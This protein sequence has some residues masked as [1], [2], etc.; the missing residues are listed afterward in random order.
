MAP[1][2]ALFTG[3]AA[4]RQP[5]PG[6][7]GLFRRDG[8]EKAIRKPDQYLTDGLYIYHLWKRLLTVQT[9][10]NECIYQCL[11][12]TDL[13]RPRIGLALYSRKCIEKC[14]FVG[15]TLPVNRQGSEIF[16]R[17]FMPNQTIRRDEWVH[18][19]GCLHLLH[20]Q[21]S[22]MSELFIESRVLW[23]WFVLRELRVIPFIFAEP[24]ETDENGELKAIL[25]TEH[26]FQAWFWRGSSRLW[27]D[28]YY[29]DVSN[30]LFA[31]IN[32]HF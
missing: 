10:E 9:G 8:L 17:N 18:L 15:Q 19:S 32:C 20:A 25:L 3:H 30:I 26:D 22:R 29:Y 31:I 27:M 7:G 21:L 14:L 24:K 23:R 2:F 5:A 12:C 6:S 13:I 1:Q 16:H 11:Q 4:L 28:E